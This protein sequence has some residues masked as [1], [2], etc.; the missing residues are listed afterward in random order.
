MPR[1]SRIDSPGMLHHIMCRGIEKR[2]VFGIDAD[3]K[4]FLEILGEVFFA[5]RP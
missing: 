4:H 5:P 2:K 1:K 3:R